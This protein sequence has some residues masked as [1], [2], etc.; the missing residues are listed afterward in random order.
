MV[1]PVTG[2]SNRN[3]SPYSIFYEISA[4]PVSWIT[5]FPASSGASNPSY[6]GY[7]GYYISCPNPHWKPWQQKTVRFFKVLNIHRIFT[8]K[9]KLKVAATWVVG[10][11]FFE[12]LVAWLEIWVWNIN[13]NAGKVSISADYHLKLYQKNIEKIGLQC[14]NYYSTK[15]TEALG[16]CCNQCPK[17]PK[18]VSNCS[19]WTAW[20]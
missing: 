8:I 12:A 7:T 17:G 11:I 20:T 9:A 3:T 5:H 2:K 14:V 1:L 16:G 6:T 18:W 19:A 4:K 15:T 13:K 10:D